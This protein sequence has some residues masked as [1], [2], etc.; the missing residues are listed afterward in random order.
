M[1][2]E[3]SELHENRTRNFIAKLKR[4][5]VLRASVPFTAEV[6]VSDEPVAYADRLAAEYRTINPGEVWGSAWQSAW[7]KLNAQVPEEWAGRTVAAHLNVNGEGLI[8]DDSGCPLYSLTNQSVFDVHYGKD[9]L[10]L[11]DCCQGGEQVELWLEAAANQLFGIDRQPNAERNAPTRHGTYTG[12]VNYLDLVVFDLEVWGLLLDFDVLFDLFHALPENAP[13]R[14][15]VLHVL[16]QAIDAYADDPDN[17]AAARAVLQ[18]LWDVPPNPGDMDVTAVGHAHIDTGW[19]WPVRETIRKSGRTFASQLWLIDRYPDYVFGASQPQHYAMV[20]EHYPDL[21]EKIK[22]A[23]ADGRWECQGGMWVEADCNLISGE[24]MVRQFV[25]GKNFFRDE[26]G[27]DVTNLWIP[28]V[29]GYS[30]A[31]PQIIQQAGCD[32]FLTQKISWSFHNEFPHNT[33]MWRGIDGTEVLTHFPP[34]NTYNTN[35][36]PNQMGQAQRRFKENG[37]ISEFISLFGIGDGGGGP[38]EEYIERGLRCQALN[39]SPKLSFGRADDFFERLKSYADELETWHGEL[40]LELHRGTLTTQARTKKGNRKLEL[41][42]R[43]TEMLCALLPADQYPREQLD[44]IWKTLLINQFHDILPGSSIQKVYEVTEAEHAACIAECDAL[45]QQAT[46][47]LLAAED[48]ALTLFNSLSA[49]YNGTVRLP[50]DWAALA[51]TADGKP[52]PVQTE[53]GGPVALVEIPAL[54]FLTLR[55]GS[56][57]ATAAPG[58]DLVLEN[59]L[60]RYEFAEDATLIAAIDKETGISV[61]PEGEMGNLFSLYIDR[62]QNWDAW[63]VDVY[64]EGELVENQRPVAAQSITAGPARPALRFELAIGQSRITQTIALPPNAKRLDFETWIDW[65]E[66]HKMLRVEFPTTVLASEATCDIQYGYVKR[67]THRNTSWDMAKFEVACHRYID[68]SDHDGGM[69]L[70]NDCKYGHKVRDHVLDLN[71]LRAPTEPDPD[72]DLG[73]HT[74]T[75]SLLPHT[76]SLIESDVQQQAAMLNQPPVVLPGLAGSAVLPISIASDGVSLKVLKRAEKGN[77]W[78]IRL[79]EIKGRRSPA[80]LT[81]ASATELVETNLLEWTEESRTPCTT[82]VEL[83]LK[84]FEIRT[85]KLE[86]A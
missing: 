8:F 2:R 58:T 57:T 11:F 71:L 30:A 56:A 74:F 86:Q 32:F 45:I 42:L 25:H 22:T 7:F 54:G 41:K 21:Y 82:P 10:R 28:D 70:L 61:L 52:V 3:L 66:C 67:P 75:Y 51:V 72:A 40:Y 4:C 64:Y 23:V 20:K 65:Q 26:F 47:Q 62:P 60:V 50:A 34:E 79:V 78:V 15:V 1:R 36:M 76:G 84:P 39:G 44:R 35:L 27:V 33:F 63:E 53:P 55:K 12:R 31:M 13:R 69:A 73:E 9:I 37:L 43:E 80:T 83:I 38:K 46:G 85:Y 29:F 68:L 49:P 19:L 77:E 48:G 16:N 6:M 17:A 59:A 5:E 81:V 18:P 14:N 24:S